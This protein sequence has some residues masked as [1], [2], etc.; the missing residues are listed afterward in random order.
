MTNFVNFTLCKRKVFALFLP[1]FFFLESH[2]QDILWEKTYGGLH[3][4]FLTDVVPTPDYGFLLAGSS[5]SDK[6][7]NKEV[8]SNGNFDYWLWK[9]NEHGTPE[10]QKSY[11]GSGMDFLQSVQLTADGGF[12]LG[13]LSS[14]AKSDHKKENSRGHDDFWVLKLDAKGNEQWQRTIGGSGQE[15]LACINRTR[16]GGY[17]IGGSSSSDKSGD[18]TED[19][20]GNLDYWVVKLNPKGDIEWQKTYGGKY[21]D[22]LKTVIQTLDGGYIIG[23]YSNSPVSGNKSNETTGIGDFWIIKTDAQGTIEWQRTLGGNGDDNLTALIPCKTGGY[24]LGGSSNSGSSG[25]KSKANRKGTDFWLVRLDEEGQ[26]LWQETYNYGKTDLLTSII[27]NEDHTFLIGGY[28][29]TETSEGKKDKKDIN[30]YIALKI[31]DKG[32]E[33]WSKTVGSEGTDVLSK[34]IE[35]RD[36]GYLLAGTSKGNSSGDKTSSQGGSDF[37]VVKLKDRHKREK[38]KSAIEAFPNPTV[39]YTNVIV[40]HDFKTGTAAVYDLAGRQL[41]QFSI[42]SRTVPV[43]LSSYPAGVYIVEI[44]TNVKNDSVKIVKAI[45]PK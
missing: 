29:Q 44:R 31:N 34:L 41:Q 22:Q 9:M 3:A 30:D 18:K 7:G 8:A 16:D 20:F 43:D 38:A 1:S 4:E 40:G 28:A 33:I 36:G 6:N 37:W 45:Q 14:S 13:G 11:G 23:G 25:D 5:L 10:W 15:L 24:L 17:I 39:Q 26:V 19:T 42:D 35:T 32:E 2:A 27:E 21:L 12:I